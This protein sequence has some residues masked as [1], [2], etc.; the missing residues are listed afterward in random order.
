MANKNKFKIEIN[1]D[2]LNASPQKKALDGQ[3]R[4]MLGL[5]GLA[6]GKSAISG[7]PSTSNYGRRYGAAA[8]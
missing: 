5:G 1:T 4:D 6:T 7:L 8:G 2:D 3:K